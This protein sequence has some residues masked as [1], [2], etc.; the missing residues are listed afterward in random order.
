[1]S[2]PIFISYSHKDKKWLDLLQTYLKPFV[3]GKQIIP[4]DDRQIQPGTDWRNA[5]KNAL[6]AA[7]V[8]VLLVSQDFLASDFI[9]KNELP[10][11]LEAAVQ[12]GLVINW[13]VV[14]SCSYE[15]SPLERYQSLGNPKEP[16]AMLQKPERE[17]ELV[18]MCGQIASSLKPDIVPSRPTIEQAIIETSSIS[19]QD[20]LTALAELMGDREV[21][22]G[23]LEFKTVFGS[24][25]NQI[26][27]LGYYKDLHDLLHTLQFKCYNYLMNIV[28]TARIRPDD[29]SV[30]ENV[31]EYEETLR[32]IVEG[33]REAAQE[34]HLITETPS[35]IT[36][37]INAL[38]E[39][40]EAVSNNDADAITIAIRPIQKVLAREPIYL[41]IRLNEA[42][43]ALSLPGLVDAL[44]KVRNRLHVESAIAN[45]FTKGVD[46]LN[47]LDNNLR[48]LRDAHD[49]WQNLDIEIRRVDGTII[50][51]LSE[52][53]YS[54]IDLKTMTEEICR[55]NDEEWARL[56]M[57]EVRKLDEAISNDNPISIK[58]HFQRYRTLAGRRFYQ[59]D[60]NL[61]ELSEKLREV[62]EP[63]TIVW[64]MISR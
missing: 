4:W 47:V 34:N 22:E 40:F 11:I 41:N 50:Q 10:P 57:Q 8:A 21:K 36:T 56:I 54:W 16:L 64:E 12:R 63:L 28:R 45:R 62:G 27:I 5:I 17:A 30:W 43:R 37:L 29:L 23:V 59:V 52:L 49:K 14:R 55:S 13:I 60:M 33:L 35:W 31:L 19:A 18:K 7:D 3:R 38:Q 42:A 9:D 58:Q 26:E 1:M 46:A 24:S 61:K 53:E 48:N 15:N 6:A 2:S 32:D 20:G 25:R 39:L 44:T 51:D